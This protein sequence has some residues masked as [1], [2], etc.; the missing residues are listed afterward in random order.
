LSKQAVA[1]ALVAAAFLLPGCTPQEGRVNL[2]ADEKIIISS[3]A[4][5]YFQTYLQKINGGKRGAFVVSE[6]GYGAYASYCPAIQGCY[7]NINY[8]SEALNSCISDGYRCVVFAKNDEIV[9]P[10]EV[11]N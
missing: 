4:W 6:D 7:Y 5:D 2:Q 1:A 9:I 3:G 8:S 10:Y 11:A